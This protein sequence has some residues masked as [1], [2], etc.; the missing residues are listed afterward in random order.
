[1]NSF[2]GCYTS[3]TV[4]TLDRRSFAAVFL[5]VRILISLEYAVLYNDYYT[6][7]MITCTALIV[8]IAVVRPYSNQNSLFNYFDPLLIFILII[9]LA[10]YRDIRMAA[11]KS[12]SN[13]RVSV[14]LS[15]ISLILPLILV[16]FSVLKTGP[17]KK[18]KILS[19]NY[20]SYSEPLEDSLEQRT[21]S[22]HV[23]SYECASAEYSLHHDSVSY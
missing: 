2:N 16:A 14:A 18:W 23:H 20:S 15:F 10:S 1:M 22:P 11:G 19:N 8:A 17:L 6:S 7:V 12:L 9:W 13:Q 5:I 4:G 21:H 3:R